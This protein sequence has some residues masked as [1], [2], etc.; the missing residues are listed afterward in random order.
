MKKQEQKTGH[1]PETT[2]QKK[3][4]SF[5]SQMAAEMKIVSRALDFADVN[6]FIIAAIA[7]KIHGFKK[8]YP[9]VYTLLLQIQN[10]HITNK[11]I[12]S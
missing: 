11:R 4:I 8:V 6:S 2:H 5:S 9:D 12:D 10:Q 7:D 3:I 1:G